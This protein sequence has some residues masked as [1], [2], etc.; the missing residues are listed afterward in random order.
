MSIDTTPPVSLKEIQDNFYKSGAVG[1]TDRYVIDFAQRDGVTWDLLDYAGQAYGLQ[2]KIFND[3]YG[4]G[5]SGLG[6]LPPDETDR[7]VDGSL[8]EVGAI[9]QWG[10][11]GLVGEDDQGKYAELRA[12]QTYGV[13]NPG[14]MQL[15][16]IWYADEAGP[17]DQYRMRATVETSDDFT[18]YGE[19]GIFVFGYR[20]GYLDGDRRTYSTWGYGERPGPSQTLTVDETFTVNDEYRH[21]VVNMNCWLPGR[22]REYDRGAFKIRDLKIEKVQP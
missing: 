20:Y 22:S 21:V 18:I 7:R 1:S 2:Y 17:G 9:S 12:Y 14:S 19:P 13:G 15:N 8:S 16:G 3:G 6:Q 5:S 4:G 10:S 11:Y